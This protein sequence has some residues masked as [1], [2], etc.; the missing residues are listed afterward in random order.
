VPISIIERDGVCSIHAGGKTPTIGEL[1]STVWLNERDAAPVASAARR[2]AGAAPDLS[3]ATAA[4]ARSAA[5]L[6]ALTPLGS[7]GQG[8]PVNSREKLV[9]VACHPQSVSSLCSVANH[10]A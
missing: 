5:S 8:L 7:A 10:R 4:V 1:V 3:A 2:L 9:F 6:Q